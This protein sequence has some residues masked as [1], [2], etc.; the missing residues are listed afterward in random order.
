[1]QPDENAGL[2]E[3]IRRFLALCDNDNPDW[4]LVP[5]AVRVL[6]ELQAAVNSEQNKGDFYGSVNS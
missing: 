1:M 2:R 4:M 3:L 5:E 6:D